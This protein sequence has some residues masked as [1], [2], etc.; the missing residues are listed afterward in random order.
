MFCDMVS[1]WISGLEQSTLPGLGF[2]LKSI[3]LTLFQQCTA[4][5]QA[6]APVSAATTVAAASAA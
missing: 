6:L 1:L 4:T 5:K 3:F 2:L